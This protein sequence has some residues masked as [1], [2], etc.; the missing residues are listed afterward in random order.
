MVLT[1]VVEVEAVEVAE[2][3]VAVVAEE[4]AVAE[5]VDEASRCEERS[6]R[7][8]AEEFMRIRAP[9]E[10][11]TRPESTHVAYRKLGGWNFADMRHQ[12]AMRHGVTVG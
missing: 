7:R 10:T 4:E 5:D 6:E 1:A 2:D 12:Q 9:R 3:A 11:A 8:Q